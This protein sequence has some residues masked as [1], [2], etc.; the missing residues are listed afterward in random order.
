MHPT[1]AHSPM[2]RL[3]GVL[4]AGLRTVFAR[5]KAS[6]AN[7]ATG[8]AAELGKQEKQLSAALM[9]VNHVGEICAQALYQSQA[10]FSRQPALQAHFEQAA[11]DELDHLAWTQ[12]RL[13]ELGSHASHLAPLWYGGAF[14][15]GALAGL[16]GDRWSLGF[17]VE[18]ERQVE[19]HLASH[20]DRLPAADL[21]SRAIVNQMRLE[22]AEHAA[23]AEQSGAAALP[24]PVPQLM[25]AAAR[26]MTSV[27]HYV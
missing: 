25:R 21:S 23:E 4:D 3:I 8:M 7:P 17:V 15:I 20:L 16:A 12:Q 9:R 2:D 18:T 14:A 13:D 6:R 10:L 5:P 11:K 26:V 24:A 1:H 19:A 27:A 22:E